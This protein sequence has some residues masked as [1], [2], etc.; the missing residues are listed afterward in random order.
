QDLP[1]QTGAP[2]RLQEHC[3]HHA[4]KIATCPGQALR[5]LLRDPAFQERFAQLRMQ[6]VQSK[7]AAQDVLVRSESENWKVVAD[8]NLVR[9][10]EHILKR[11]ERPGNLQGVEFAVSEVVPN[12]Q[13]EGA[14]SAAFAAAPDARAYGTIAH[15]PQCPHS[16][17]PAD[18]HQARP[19][20]REE[21]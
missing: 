12:R 19:V 20:W 7:I 5:A 11:C 15:P 18:H 9:E 10:L 16:P 13:L 6:G 17:K 3:R 21:V 2:A 1:L 14:E 8:K 4:L